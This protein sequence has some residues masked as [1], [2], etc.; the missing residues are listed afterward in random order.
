MSVA[1]RVVAGV[2][3]DT[4]KHMQPGAG[5]VLMDFD[6]KAIASTGAFQESFIAALATP[7]NL[8]GTRGGI[9][10]NVVPEK[11]QREV[12]GANVRF[13]GDSVIDG[14]E[15]YLSCNLVEF[16]AT[17]LKAAFPTADIDEDVA[18]IAKIRIKTAI[19]ADDHKENICWIATTDFGYIMFALHNALGQTT[20]EISSEAQGESTIPFR[21]DGFVSDFAEIDYAPC[22]IWL[23]DMRGGVIQRQKV[24]TEETET[25]ETAVAS[26][27]GGVTFA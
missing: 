12:D 21:A 20:G 14:W 7:N 18:D 11:R 22:D 19:S 16:T 10:I 9:N 2:T 27:E 4:F 25:V 23:V 8:G 24:G 3:P 6:Y 17:T 15:C 13:K 5:A 26:E 1:T